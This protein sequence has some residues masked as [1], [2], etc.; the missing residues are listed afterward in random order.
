MRVALAPWYATRMRSR[1]E[2]NNTG[3][4][5]SVC[6]RARAGLH[7]VVLL[8]FVACSALLLPSAS[9]HPQFALSTVNRYGKLLLLRGGQLRVLY[10]LM[11]GDV[12][13]LSLRQSADRDGNGLL[14]AQEQQQ[15]ASRLAERIVGGVLL[16]EHTQ[17][18]TVKWQ[19][20]ALTLSDTKVAPTAF[21][22]ELS[23][24]VPL[25]VPSTSEGAASLYV[26]KYEDHVELPTASVGEV[27]LRIEEGPGTRVLSTQSATATSPA[28]SGAQPLIFQ[29][30]GPP[31]SSLTDR[32]I[33]IQFSELLAPQKSQQR[34]RVPLKLLPVPILILVLVGLRRLRK[35][36]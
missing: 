5:G 21:A 27:E 3:R 22:L 19:P 36:K 12:P 14:D 4:F 24:S 17:P 11:I 35:Q 1:I 18:L 32:S 7:A 8:G 30:F 34:P 16:H 9:A 13:A 29:H 28:G 2:N 15:L 10:T 33:S 26:L 25:A 23:G 20:A 6:Q 31:R